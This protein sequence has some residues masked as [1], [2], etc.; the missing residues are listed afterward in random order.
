MQPKL[1]RSW[2]PSALLPMCIQAFLPPHLLAGTKQR[3]W[4]DWYLFKEFQQEEKEPIIET[5]THW[6]GELQL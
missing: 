4:L 3:R 6:Q 5:S 1:H 2:F